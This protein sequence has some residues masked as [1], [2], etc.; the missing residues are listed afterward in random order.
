LVLVLAAFGMLIPTPAGM[1][2]VHYALGVLLPAIAAVPGARA[3]L[4]AIV[5]HA[6]QFLPIIV[7]GLV[8]AAAEGLGAGEIGRYA[9]ESEAGG[10]LTDSPN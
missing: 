10:T 3:K 9:D 5:F 8:A 6:S 1:G 7:A 4:L 2:T